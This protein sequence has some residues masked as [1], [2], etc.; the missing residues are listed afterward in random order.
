MNEIIQSLFSALGIANTEAYEALFF[1]AGYRRFHLVNGV[2]Q[3]GG[4]EFM[5]RA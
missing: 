4:T 3:A 2:V 1:E 5:H